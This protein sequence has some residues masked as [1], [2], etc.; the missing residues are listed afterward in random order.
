MQAV[1]DFTKSN[2]KPG[3][4]KAIGLENP[5]AVSL[6]LSGDVPQEVRAKMDELR[7]AIVRDEIE[8]S[9]E[10]GGPEVEM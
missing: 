4:V 3:V 2:W 9:T 10:Y 8:V 7:E 1:E 6:T 5:D